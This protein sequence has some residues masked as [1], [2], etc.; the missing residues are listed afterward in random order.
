M[1]ES[2]ATSVVDK[3]CLHHQFRN[4]IVLGSG[5]FPSASPSNP[6]L[7]IASLS[8]YSATNLFR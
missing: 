2:K 4:L 1:G 6:S 3:Q 5:N 8:M 7:T